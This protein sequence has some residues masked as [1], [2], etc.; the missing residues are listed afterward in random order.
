MAKSKECIATIAV[1]Y[2]ASYLYRVLIT[3]IILHVIHSIHIQLCIFLLTVTLEAMLLSASIGESY[4]HEFSRMSM[5]LLRAIQWDLYI[6]PIL[7]PSIIVS[8]DY[9]GV[10]IIQ[11]SEQIHVKAP[12]VTIT[13]CVNYI[14][15]SSVLIKIFHA[16]MDSILYIC[17]YL[18]IYSS[19][20][21]IALM[22]TAY[23]LQESFC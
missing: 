19:V 15:I 22:I 1:Q 7:E 11:V 18:V 3:E 20:Y 2:I 16:C 5:V 21:V 10:L 4:S 17:I 6:I 14:I 8:P 23:L 9:Q 12:F 13:K